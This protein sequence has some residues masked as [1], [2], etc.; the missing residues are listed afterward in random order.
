MLGFQAERQTVGCNRKTVQWGELGWVFLGGTLKCNLN[1]LRC[2]CLF[3]SIYNIHTRTI[4][5]ILSIRLVKGQ[6]NYYTLFV[7]DV[8]VPAIFKIKHI[9]FW[10]DGM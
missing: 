4:Y 1:G 8:R 10:P 3:T 2:L 5:Y 6:S 9:D 7:S